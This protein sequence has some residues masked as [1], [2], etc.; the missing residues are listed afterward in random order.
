MAGESLLQWRDVGHIN[1][2]NKDGD[3]KRVPTLLILK[4]QDK[5][6]LI[7]GDKDSGDWGKGHIFCNDILDIHGGYQ[8]HLLNVARLLDF[9]FDCNGVEI[10]GCVNVWRIS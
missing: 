5:I 4:S 2:G 1:D 9:C 10:T 8:C 3:V 6:V 7:V